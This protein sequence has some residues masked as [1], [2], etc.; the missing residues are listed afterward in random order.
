MKGLGLI[1]T[2]VENIMPLVVK[3]GRMYIEAHNLGIGSE[4]TIR[5]VLG[6]NS[7]AKVTVKMV[8]D[9]RFWPTALETRQDVERKHYV[10]DD[11][12]GRFTFARQE[13][14]GAE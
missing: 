14:P 9:G 1:I 3:S 7:F 11:R 12:F 4:G 6:T 5:F 13:F 10:W 2:E 8:G